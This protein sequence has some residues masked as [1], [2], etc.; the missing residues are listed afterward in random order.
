MTTPNEGGDGSLVGPKEKK[1][2]DRHGCTVYADDSSFF[3]VCAPGI[4]IVMCLKSSANFYES[5]S[6][7]ETKLVKS[8]TTSM[9]KNEIVASLWG[10]VS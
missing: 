9:K 6:E 3:C 7:M 8:C 10:S 4:R 2:V 5:F 1:R